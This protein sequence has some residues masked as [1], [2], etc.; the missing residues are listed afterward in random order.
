MQNGAY[1]VEK[2]GS[3]LY[4]SR[5][6]GANANPSASWTGLNIKPIE[7]QTR[8]WWAGEGTGPTASF[9]LTLYF[10]DGT[11]GT[12]SF[13][14]S[15]RDTTVTTTLSSSNQKQCTKIVLSGS[16]TVGA[17]VSTSWSDNYPKITKWKE[18]EYQ[19]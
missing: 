1:G 15:G 5:G 10:K 13:S 12:H 16:D 4:S 7:I 2:A 8:W 9:N 18:L 19:G 11:T 6:W 3:I 14:G 17:G